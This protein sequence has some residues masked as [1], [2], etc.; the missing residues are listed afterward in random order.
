MSLTTRILSLGLLVLAAALPCG[1][2]RNGPEIVPVEGT[3][4]YGGGPWPKPGVV[5]FTLDPTASGK[6]GHP[7]TGKFGVDGK[8][9]VTT[10]GKDGLV[11]GKY[12]LSVE[13]WEVP[14]RMGSPTPPVSYVPERYQS[15][16]TSGLSLSVESGKRVVHVQL[17][18]P[19][20]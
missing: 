8:L 9:T 12:K 17:D 5:Y 16:A 14:P 15:A 18:V 2:G 7:V 4:T 13:C 11:P 10:F 19:K 20:K 3:I 6:S 1:C